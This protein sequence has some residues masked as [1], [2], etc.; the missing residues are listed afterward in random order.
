MVEPE[1][2]NHAIRFGLLLSGQHLIGADV[3]THLDEHLEQT[4]LAGEQGFAGVFY[5][6][7]F[8]TPTLV[9]PHQMVFLA[10]V[11]AEA[12]KMQ[13]G[14]ALTL[15][16]LK[17]PV[18]LADMAA[19]LDHITHGRFILGLGLG[20]RE[21][22][23]KAFGLTRAMAPAIFD[24][25]LAVLKRLWSEEE[26]TYQGHGFT[27]EKATCTLRPVQRPHPPIWIGANT[28]GA[29]RRAAMHGDAWLIN[30]HARLDV[31]T[32]Q[33]RIYH[34]TRVAHGLPRPENFPLVREVFVAE[35]R[36]RAEALAYPALEQK[37]RTY[38]E[39]GQHRA[40]PPTDPLDVPLPQLIQRRFII[41]TPDDVIRD[42][43]TCIEQLG[44]NYIIV[45]MQW[46][47]MA[48]RATARAIKL[49]GKYVIP[50]F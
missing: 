32:E 6:E 4:R 42:L 27:L 49:M 24:E 40:M 44:V 23:Y 48:H 5:S 2:E 26:I 47:G 37:Y 10:R 16:P 46:P 34:E 38:V 11:A 33:I 31:L 9:R 12:G 13:V 1:T 3:T 43:E 14:T 28:E 45:R 7:H 21:I 17:N 18:E 50:S 20:Y 41:G 15:L 39:A 29:I 8:L 36:T 22:E 30:P 35:T 19:T 25:R